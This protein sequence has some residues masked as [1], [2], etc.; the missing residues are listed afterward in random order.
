MPK[1]ETQKPGIVQRVRN[2]FW[3]KFQKAASWV[4]RTASCIAFGYTAAGCEVIASARTVWDNATLVWEYKSPA[5]IANVIRWTAKTAYSAVLAPV[6]GAVYASIML[7]GDDVFVSLAASADAALRA[8]MTRYIAGVVVPA[9]AGSLLCWPA[10]VVLRVVGG[11]QTLEA[12]G[13]AVVA[14]VHFA[15]ARNPFARFVAA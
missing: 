9:L 4:S 5:C 1:T 11:L 13:N 6:R 14:V 12:L 3:S 7:A 8:G 2:F 10:Y 15:D